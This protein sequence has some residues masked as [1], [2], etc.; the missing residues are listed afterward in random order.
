MRDIFLRHAADLPALA[1]CAK[2]FAQG[3]IFEN[4]A[5]SQIPEGN[6]GGNAAQAVYHDRGQP[7]LAQSNGA[8]TG[9]HCFSH[10][11][12]PGFLQLGRDPTDTRVHKMTGRAARQGFSLGRRGKNLENGCADVETVS[13]EKLFR[14]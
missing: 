9:R 14:L 10:V 13:F 7:P 12:L 4:A 3:T 11:I 8:A 6:T 2:R 1:G 5:D